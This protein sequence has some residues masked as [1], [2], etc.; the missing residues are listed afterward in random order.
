MKRYI[1][2]FL[3][4]MIFPFIKISAQNYSVESIPDSLKENAHCVIRVFNRE[5]KLQ[6]ANSGVQRIK[7]AITILDKA[8][9]GDAYFIASYDKNSSININRITLYDNRGEKIRSIKQTEIEDYPAY[10]SSELF[11]EN[12][13]KHFQPEYPAF[14]YTVEYDY[15]I[16]ADNMI[17]Y[18]VMR[19]FSD[20]NISAEHVTFTFIH[21]V[22][23]K[24]CKKEVNI[25]HVSLKQK[26]KQEVETWELNNLKAIE[27]EPFDVSFIERVPSVYL[28][29]A[30]LIYEKYE[31]SA[32]NWEEFG[33]W[34]YSLYK[35]RDELPDAEREKVAALIKNI[36][37]TLER[38]K[39]LYRFMQENTRYVAVTLGIGGYQPFSVKTVF[40]TGYGDCKALT[41][42][43]YSILK[44]SG[45]RSYP[46]LVA[47]GSYKVPIFNDF[48]NFQQFDH[49]ILFIPLRNDSIW[50][51]CTNQKIPFGFLGSFTNDRDVLLITEKG[52]K[53]A[54]TSKYNAGDNLRICKSQ[55]VINP[56]GTADCIITTL[57]QGLQYDNI[58]G[59]LNSDYEAQKKWLYSNSNLPALTIKS[60]SIENNK[61]SLPSAR[62]IENSVSKNYCS[63]SGNYM[64]LPINQLNAQKP[65]A[66]MLRQRYSDV[67][68]IESFTDYDTVEYKIPDK[69]KFESIPSGSVLNSSFGSYS[70]AV[71]GKE[72]K[73]VYTRK[74]V[75]K[76]GRYKPSEYKNLY[77][78][79]LSISKAD[80]TKI[81]LSKK[82]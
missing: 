66:R 21:P 17:S 16:K 26:D 64:V 30:S 58:S 71:S 56:D 45:I 81:L 72:D 10:S 31:G 44:S 24:I 43:M 80:N 68:I 9:E 55:F 41:N 77:D 65:V 15:E 57:M 23:I 7:K 36:P 3:I 39:T 75:I 13:L 60:F 47:S 67:L 49:V 46:A 61:K 8:G 20:Y 48:P 50:L 2:L 78:F 18:G 42:F 35:G 12:R 79:L 4:V 33:K 5:L 70:W 38:I 59:V 74:L 6:S 25:T 69:F 52:G 27:D 53:F 1:S 32:T 14:P 82:I 19:P 11:S 37:D 40:E 76:E 51:E 28:M 54:H 22:D 73:I 34:M 62:L 63:F 29:P